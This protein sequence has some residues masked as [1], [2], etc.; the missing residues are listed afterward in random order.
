[1]GLIGIAG[2]ASLCAPVILATVGFLP[3]PEPTIV[4]LAAGAG[5][6][7]LM[8]DEVASWPNPVQGKGLPWRIILL[9]GGPFAA[10][11][12]WALSPAEERASDQE[13]K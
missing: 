12:L 8:L 9:I 5:L 2:A 13:L 10:I 1:M 7:G 11:A 6:W 4:A 3:V